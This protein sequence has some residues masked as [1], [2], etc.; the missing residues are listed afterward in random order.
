MSDIDSYI[1]NVIKQGDEGSAL[2]AGLSAP[3]LKNS[4]LVDIIQEGMN[5][6]AVLRIPEDRLCVVHSIGGDVHKS[7]KLKNYVESMVDRL[8]KGS[9]DIGAIPLGFADVIDASEGKQD[10][11]KNIGRTLVEKANKYNLPILNGELA[12]LGARV[13]TVANVSGTMI[14]MIHKDQFTVPGVFT[15][16]G[17][18]YAVFDPKGK[19]VWINSDGIGTKTD[20]YERFDTWEK[21]L[22]DSVAMK[23]DDTIKL[24][25]TAQ[26]ISDIVESKGKVPFPKLVR[27]AQFIAKKMKC[28][29]ILQW[30]YAMESMINGFNPDLN[31]P[32][33]NVSGSVVSTIDE[34]RLKNPLIPEKGEYLI[35]IKG[36]SN[37]RSN[38]ITDKRKMMVNLFGENWHKTKEGKLFGQ[39]LAQ[40]SIVFYPLFKEM[41]EQGVATSVYHMS[42]GAYDGKLAKP[43]AKQGLYVELNNLFMP[44]FRELSIMGA[45][46][47]SMETA[48]GKWPM[49]NDGFVTVKEQDVEKAQT[50]IARHGLESKIVGM[51]EKRN[52]GLTGVKLT[53]PS[54]GEVVYYS[55]KAA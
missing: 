33:Y 45:M 2:L 32:A 53:A 9:Q 54:N 21:G 29:Y 52:D 8:V 43:L 12:I 5:G 14:S 23:V 41:I 3:T 20:L 38:G 26:V 13:A 28:P 1:N 44:D 24:G 19:A 30:E 51:I 10:D 16:K 49:C 27:E 7:K 42:G 34:E 37:P 55:G 40:P 47:A 4:K 31:S 50:L 22:W 25:A 18:T 48:Y 46:G 15:A 35:A 6:L 17:I 36:K 11:I 39:Y